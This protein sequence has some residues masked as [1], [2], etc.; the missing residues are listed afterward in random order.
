MQA[1]AQARVAASVAG[2]G[3]DLD[4]GLEWMDEPDGIQGAGQHVGEILKQSLGHMA[5]LLVP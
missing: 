3:P 2:S 5:M 1:T 4:D